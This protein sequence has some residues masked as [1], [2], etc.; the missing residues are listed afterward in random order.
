[1]FD[2]ARFTKPREERHL[3][4]A[5]RHRRLHADIVPGPPRPTSPPLLVALPFLLV[6]QH[7]QR[8]P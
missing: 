4:T 2:S 8:P 5:H 6:D 7:Q 1:M 3:L